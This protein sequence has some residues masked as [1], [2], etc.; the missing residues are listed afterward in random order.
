MTE[1]LSL[2]ALVPSMV[3]LHPVA[4]SVRCILVRVP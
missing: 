2:V 1:P 4:A 3:A